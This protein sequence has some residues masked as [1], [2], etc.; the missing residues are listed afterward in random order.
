[1]TDLKQYLPQIIAMLTLAAGG[2]TLGVS[3]YNA[4]DRADDMRYTAAHTAGVSADLAITI[5]KLE[6]RISKLEAYRGLESDTQ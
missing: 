1:M 2:G 5:Y 3:Q 4:S 6:E